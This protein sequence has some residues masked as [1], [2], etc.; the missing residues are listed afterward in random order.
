MAFLR[1]EGT[2]RNWWQPTADALLTMQR[3][4]QLVATV[5]NGSQVAER[6]LRPA[7]LPAVAVGCL[8]SAPQTLHLWGRCDGAGPAREARDAD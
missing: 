1:R 4:S 8:R 3:W 6:V 2:S 7:P 5:S